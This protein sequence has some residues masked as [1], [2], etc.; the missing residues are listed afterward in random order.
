MIVTDL[1]NSS[2]LVNSTLFFFMLD[3]YIL[4]A[5]QIRHHIDHPYLRES[6]GH[7]GYSLRPS[8]RGK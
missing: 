1:T 8:A 7:I 2:R 6:G 3:D 5:I 4:G